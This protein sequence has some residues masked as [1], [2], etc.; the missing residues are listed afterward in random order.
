M[1]HSQ[2]NV[3][4]VALTVSIVEIVAETKF[5]NLQLQNQQLN[6]QA[7]A[8]HVPLPFWPHSCSERLCSIVLSLVDNPVVHRYVVVA[9]G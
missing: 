1:L 3:S 7:P 9:S 6:A 5:S 4:P 8:D 2:S